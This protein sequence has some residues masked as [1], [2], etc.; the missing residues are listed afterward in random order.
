LLALSLV[1][2]ACTDPASATVAPVAVDEP[3][4][5]LEG[6]TLDGGRFSSEDLA[7]SPM[8]VNA[9]ASWCVECETETPQLIA[10]SREYADEG[11]RFVGINHGDQHAAATAFAARYGVPYPSLE[12]P[13]GRYAASFGYLGLP[14]TFV[15][16]ASGTIRWAIFG[17]TDAEQLA[18]LIDDVLAGDAPS[19]GAG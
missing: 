1:A 12:D 4:P 16:D 18:P 6:E 13:A 2:A 8:V 10:L 14:A 9:W 5:L 17:P 19:E 3:L 11:V 7:G 15:V